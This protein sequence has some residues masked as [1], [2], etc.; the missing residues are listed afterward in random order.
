MIEI[1][2]EDIVTPNDFPELASK[3]EKIE[4]FMGETTYLL[5]NGTRYTKEEL[6]P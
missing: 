6:Q 1:K 3:V 2:V 4:P 5:E